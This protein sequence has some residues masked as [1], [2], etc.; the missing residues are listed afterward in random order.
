[1]LLEAIRSVILFEPEFTETNESLDAILI[2]MKPQPN[3]KILAICGSGEQSKILAKKGSKVLAVDNNFNQIRYARGSLFPNRGCE[4]TKLKFQKG[5]VFDEK[6]LP[7][8]TFDSIYLSNALGYSLN[9][10]MFINNKIDPDDKVEQFTYINK[11]LNL[12]LNRLK[13]R[14]HLYMADGFNLISYLRDFSGKKIEE[15]EYLP[16]TNKY[17]IATSLQRFEVEFKSTLNSI[18]IERQIGGTERFQPV[19][20]VKK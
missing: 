7:T 14:G 3:Q 15:S 19:V 2:G 18:R 11:N 9:W 1:M 17:P 20:L 4:N 5:D 12:T 10:D 13:K 6:F 8:Q 16:S